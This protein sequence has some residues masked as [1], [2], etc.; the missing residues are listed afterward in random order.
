MKPIPQIRLKEILTPIGEARLR[1]ANL[2]GRAN[3]DYSI[4]Q[5]TLGYEMRMISA[6]VDDLDS[7]TSCLVV[8]TCRS[9]LDPAPVCGVMLFWVKPEARGNAAPLVADMFKTLES[10]AA[11][12]TCESITASSWVYLGSEDT[13]AL[14]SRHGF[15]LQ[16]RVFHKRMKD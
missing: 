8:R 1:E 16:E 3:V 6:F 15:D 13:D 11:M 10:F 14:W 9:W 7:P 4:S 5:V 2:E 12:N